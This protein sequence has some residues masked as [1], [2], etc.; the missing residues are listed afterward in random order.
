MLIKNKYYSQYDFKVK[1]NDHTNRY[2]I[3]ATPKKDTIGV[4]VGYLRRVGAIY[5]STY[6]DV[7]EEGYW[8]T[9]EEAE[10]FL[11]HWL[12]YWLEETEF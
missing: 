11:G 9:S 10:T 5:T 2:Y 7:L 6:S 8:E 1:F 12:E 3:A 4:P